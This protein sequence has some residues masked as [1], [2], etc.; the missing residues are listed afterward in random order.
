MAFV[1]LRLYSNYRNHLGLHYSCNFAVA[2]DDWTTQW[3]YINHLLDVVYHRVTMATVSWL[4][5]QMMMMM[6]MT[7]VLAGY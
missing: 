2:H 3:L 1:S 4:L 7:E 5:M 6:M